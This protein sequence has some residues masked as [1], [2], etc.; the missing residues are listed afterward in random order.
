MNYDGK[1]ICEMCSWTGFGPIPA[2]LARFRSRPGVLRLVCVD[3]MCNMTKLQENHEFRKISPLSSKHVSV[4]L[5]HKS[6]SSPVRQTTMHHFITEM[7]AYLCYKMVHCGIYLWCLGWFVTWNFADRCKI[8][9]KP[10][11]HGT[12]IHQRFVLVNSLHGV[13]L[14]M[15]NTNYVANESIAFKSKLCCNWLTDFDSVISVW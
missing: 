12:L 5:S 4:D 13:V 14:Y 6:H 1:S 2:A 7:C 8:W 11:Y 10:R 9:R 3:N 15:Y